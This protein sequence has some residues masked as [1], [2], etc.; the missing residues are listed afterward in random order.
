MHKLG[1]SGGWSGGCKKIRVSRKLE[2]MY[3]CFIPHFD[4]WGSIRM[5]WFTSLSLPDFYRSGQSG[6]LNGNGKP[7]F[8]SPPNEIHKIGFCFPKRLMA[9]MDGFTTDY[10]SHRTRGL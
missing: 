6:K 5:G 10:L 1:L 4:G 7:V 8:I 2:M 3:I 9:G